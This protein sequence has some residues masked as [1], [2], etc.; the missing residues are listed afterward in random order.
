MKRDAVVGKATF[1]GKGIRSA[2]QRLDAFERLVYPEEIAVHQIDNLKRTEIKR[3][4]DK[5]QNKQG[6]SMAHT[7]LAY[8]SAVFNWHASN[9]DGFQNP[10]VRGMGRVKPKERA[11]TRVLTDDE[12]R[13]V[14]KALDTTIERLPACYAAYVRTLLLTALRRTEGTQGSWSED[15]LGPRLPRSDR[16]EM[17]LLTEESRPRMARAGHTVGAAESDPDRKPALSAPGFP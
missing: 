16:T 4:L 10:I 7:L 15:S 14:W 2:K 17:G 5:I 9:T 12:I 8:L 13:D 6:P 11:R 3:L 1:N